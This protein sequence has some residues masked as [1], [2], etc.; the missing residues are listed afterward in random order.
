[1][2][3]KRIIIEQ[4]DGNSFYQGIKP[5]AQKSMEYEMP[6]R[7]QSFSDGITNSFWRAVAVGFAFLAIFIY[8]VM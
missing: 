2:S 8:L 6:T 7:G 3:L 4:T 1:M 5:Q